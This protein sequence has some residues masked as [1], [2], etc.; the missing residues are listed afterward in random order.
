MKFGV[1]WSVKGIWPEAR[2][3][4]KEAARRSGMSL[5]EWLNSVI[6]H[7]AAE[8]GVQ[9][10]S[11]AYDDD[12]AGGDKL[13]TVHQRL[14]DLTR[15]IE[16]FTRTGPAVYAPKRSRNDGDQIAELIGRLDR[17]LDQFVNSSRPTAAPLA[18]AM[19]L[20][21]M[22]GMPPVLDRAIAEIT[23][24]QRALNGQPAPAGQRPQGPV[25][26]PMPTPAP[27]SVLAPVLAP[28]PTQDLS[29][30]EDQL[31]RITDQIETLRKPGV[32][33]AINALRAELGEIGRALNDAMP[34]RAIDAIEKQI[35]GL[36]HRIAEGRQAGSDGGALSGVEHG[37]AEVRDALRRLTPAEN[38]VGFNDAVAALAHKIDL[39]VAQKDPAT[40]QQLE[41]AITTLRDMA[42][43]VASNDAVSGLATQVQM[44]GE[45]VEHISLSG[46]ASDALNNLEHRIA[47]LSDA[48][49]ERAQN[50]GTVPPMLEALVQSLSDKIE[51]IQQSRGD[52]VAVGHLEDRIVTLVERLVRGVNQFN[53]ETRKSQATAE[54]QFVEGRA[55]E[56]GRA[57]REVEDRL[58]TFLQRNRAIGGSP[59]LG[60]ERDRLQ[61]EVALRQQVYTTLLQT[62]EEA[63]IREVR[64]MPVITELEDPRLPLIS[65]S[66]GTA[67]KLI[68]GALAGGFLGIVIAFLADAMVAAR[69][70]PSEE[71]REFF[72]LVEEVTPRFLKRGAR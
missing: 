55:E 22:P 3:T 31:R 30:L 63:R 33:E 48:L 57:L 29:G 64:D 44:L 21:A 69:R 35:Q 25:A 16:Q 28:V 71:A 1:P 72:Q 47:A 19:M 38:L 70:A 61:R 4:A 54:R 14:D 51:L 2:E 42:G 58:Q 15:R 34:R 32:E 50:G 9:S 24:R 27:P 26:A 59:E 49:A 65:E 18:P 37:L 66:R 23:A 41:H 56:A 67:I 6:L 13:S 10:P 11:L 68:L 53:L 12:D 62:R 7:K 36:T 52:N 20:P 45:K 17:R 46:G 5:G 60:F 40:L 39:I 8:D 43:H